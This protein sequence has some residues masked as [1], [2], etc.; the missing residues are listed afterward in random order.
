MSQVDQ[1]NSLA[2]GEDTLISMGA[3]QSLRRRAEDSDRSRVLLPLHMVKEMTP[4]DAQLLFHE[5]RVHQIEL[6]LQNEELRRVQVELELA[7]ERYFDLYDMAP[8]GY[9][10]VNE[11]GL[12]LEANLT[13]A[14]MLGVAR[15]VLVKRPL[16]SFMHK[17]QQHIYH[18]CC[19]QLRANGHT[20]TCDLQ[21]HKV[22]GKL[23][24]VNLAANLSKGSAGATTLRVTLRD[25]TDRVGLDTQLMEKN[26]EL[27]LTRL[28]ADKANQAKS[29]FLASMSHEL[30]SPLNAILGFAQL[31]DAGRPAPT[32]AQKSAIDQILHGGW[33]LL[34][35]INEILDLASIESGKLSMA[36]SPESLADVLQDCKTLIEPQAAAS[37]VL[38][39]FP[40]F[41]QPC[42]V[43]ADRRRL[44]QVMINLLSN[45]IKYNHAKGTV[46]V[47][48]SLCPGGRVRISL[49]DSGKGLT[50]D[51]LAQLFQP[52]NRLGQEAG[53]LEGTGIGLVVSK[54]L[55]ELM[56]GSIGA[57]STPGVGSLFWFDLAL[58]GAG[59]A[60]SPAAP[61][62]TLAAAPPLAGSAAALRTVLY[63]EDN[64]ANM[65]LVE[66]LIARR[67]DMQLLKANNAT[68]GL[69][70]ATTHL[71]QL[72]LMDINLPGM[73]GLQARKLLLD[74]AAT[75]HIPVL[76]I[77]ANAM[78]QEIEKA[79]AGGFFAYL[80]K[81]IRMDEFMAALDKGLALAASAT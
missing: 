26:A 28:V 62:P 12:V 60:P 66:Q 76:A 4:E 32:P 29:E 69:A 14:T 39:R 46:D 77:S 65:A 2:A 27:E 74:N 10:T 35:L 81:P 16:T 70:L 64:P 6:E 43:R 25:I 13:A 31:M 58:D 54:R 24:W 78:P 56:G 61:S 38:V 1:N 49:Q 15:S 21:M 11:E 80:T 41:D 52:F 48:W 68:Q 44:K 19:Q 79:L 17:A 23:I 42:F 36:V 75:R 3:L 30:R 55:V 20:Q 22:D 50:T 57:H 34:E 8:V 67:A 47:S 7:R 59:G 5:L 63:V 9:C 37:D 53:P 45:A 72:I 71:P 33:Y 73:D 18:A 40:S 51:Q